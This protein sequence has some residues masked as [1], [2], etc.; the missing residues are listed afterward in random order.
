MRSYIL[1]N[2]LLNYIIDTVLVLNPNHLFE[3]SR[4]ETLPLFLGQVRLAL[5]PF[6][7][8][9]PALPQAHRRQALQ[10]QGVRPLLR[11]I[12][13]PRPAHE[14]AHAQEH[15]VNTAEHAFELPSVNTLNEV[16][17]VNTDSQ[18]L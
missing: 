8:A 12:R 11:P 15:Q 18:E 5:R 13:P 3:F 14:E 9:D 6:G 10:V 4:R 1:H 16:L 2:I 7:R 17:L